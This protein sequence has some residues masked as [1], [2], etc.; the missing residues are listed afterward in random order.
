MQSENQLSKRDREK[1]G[2]LNRRLEGIERILKLEEHFHYNDGM[3]K[4][5]TTREM[6]NGVLVRAA[7]A[8]GK[9]A[10]KLT[11]LVASRGK[12]AKQ[13]QAKP[14]KPRPS[15]TGASK[16]K[17]SVPKSAS[18]KPTTAKKRRRKAKAV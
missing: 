7:T 12:P 16:T 4:K 2:S 10:G 8:L 13:D 3:A 9:A 1:S 15:K 6:S 5:K 14:R 11:A 17:G 18:T